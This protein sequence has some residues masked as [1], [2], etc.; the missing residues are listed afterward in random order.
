MRISSV[1]ALVVSVFLAVPAASARMIRTLPTASGA[2]VTRH[3]GRKI[4]APAPTEYQNWRIRNQRRAKDLKH[5][6]NALFLYK[7]AH[8]GTPPSQIKLDQ[9]TEICRYDAKNCTGLLD[10]QEA[11]T[12]YLAT[13]PA[14][15]SASAK[16]GNGTRYLVQKDHKGRVYLL[17][18]DAEEGWLIREMH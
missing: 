6:A 2:H 14:D 11:L 13:M 9:N 17:A 5:I 18:P 1:A 15:P 12:P 4:K 8:D 10:L 16:T 3:A 7:K